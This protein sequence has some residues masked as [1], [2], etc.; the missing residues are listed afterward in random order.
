MPGASR[1]R[2]RPRRCAPAGADARRS[3]PER[4]AGEDEHEPERGVE[5]DLLV[6]DED[7]VDERDGRQQV[8]DERGAR[9][10]VALQQAVEEEQ[11]DRRPEDAE[12]HDRADRLPARHL[13]RPLDEGEGQ[14]DQ[15]SGRTRDARD[16]ERR[17]GA[18][19]VLDEVV[20]ARIRERGDDDR[21]RARGRVPAALRLQPREHANAGEPDE[22][23]CE[24]DAV[25]AL[26]RIEP[27]REQDDE[28]RHG[29]VRDRG[30]A[31]V[32]VLL[33]P[34]DEDE[35]ERRVEEADCEALPAGRPQLAHGL[36]RAQPPDQHRQEHRGGKDEPEEHHR[37]RLDLVHGDLDEQVRRTPD[38]GDDREQ[39]DVAAD[40]GPEA[41]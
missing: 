41:T 12:R 1:A 4:D 33:A 17:S 34:G 2:A 35:R 18:V 7:P 30:D 26:A 3:R 8:G 36:A 19:V 15:R 27:E 39:W 40:H 32:D 13:L 23:P 37:R 5:R 21:Q 14:Q 29:C 6:E 10:A 28:D 25:D 31:G 16:H 20:R 24:P 9:G 22:D 11:R 38:R